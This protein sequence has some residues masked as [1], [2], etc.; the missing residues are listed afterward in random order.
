MYRLYALQVTKVVGKYHIF[1]KGEI[2]MQERKFKR[3]G[4][5]GAGFCICIQGG[6]P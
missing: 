6:Q 1:R 5:Y 2:F 4:M 3:K